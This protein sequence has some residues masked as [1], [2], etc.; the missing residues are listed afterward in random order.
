MTVPSKFVRM[1]DHV[2][3]TTDS[4]VSVRVATAENIAKVGVT[5][6]QSGL[7]FFAIFADLFRHFRLKT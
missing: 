1:A 6:V 4:P 2:K 3:I 7:F 5:L